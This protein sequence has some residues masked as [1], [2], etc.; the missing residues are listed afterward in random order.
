VKESLGALAD[1]KLLKDKGRLDQ[2]K[3]GAKKKSGEA[4]RRIDEVPEARGRGPPLGRTA[5]S[6]SAAARRRVARRG[7]RYSCRR[8]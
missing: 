6:R 1:H 5:G 3:G 7:S 2:A 8:L 4:K